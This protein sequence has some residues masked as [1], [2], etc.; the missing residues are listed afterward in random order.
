MKR[1]FLTLIG[2]LVAVTLLA[3]GKVN[4]RKY[5]LSDFT[6]KVTQVVLTGDELLDSA[7]QQEIV[8]SW[9]SSPFEFCTLER[10]ESIKTSEEYYFLIPA[11]SRFKNED[12][13]GI[14]FLSLVKGGPEAAEGIGKMLDVISLPLTSAMGGSGRELIYLGAI[15]NSI[16]DYVLASMESEKIAYLKDLWFNENYAKTGKM[17][18]IYLSEQ[19]LSEQLDPQ[20]LN[21]YLDADI[22]VVDES[23]ADKVFLDGEFNSLVSYV[24]APFDPDLG[25]SYCYKL[26][27]DAETHR[28]HYIQKHKITEKTGS[29]FTVADLKKIA[30]KR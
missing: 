28:L 10:F 11:E 15:V 24:V 12:T 2:L 30:K 3:Q 5:I 17:K 13:P 22:H 25:S 6:D 8:R 26:L 7:L 9:T 23:V 29:G 19:D 20:E 27:F 18:Q 1:V 14:R 4:T 21:R 16:Q